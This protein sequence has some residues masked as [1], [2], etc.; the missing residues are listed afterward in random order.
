MSS[1][2]P[3][4]ASLRRRRAALIALLIVLQLVGVASGWAAQPDIGAVAAATRDGRGR[5]ILDLPD[6]GAS[7][8]PPESFSVAV[9]GRPLPA[10]AVPIMSD[11]L[12]MALVVDASQ[13]GRPVL[14]PGLS[15][16]VDFALA[17]SPTTRSTVVAD[18]SPPAVV[19]P[20][21]PGPAA[22]LEG[23]SSI[24]PQGE[25]QTAAAL[26][27]AVQQLPVEADDPRLVVLYTAAEAAD[28]PAADLVA[29][30]TA[31]G[32][33]LAVV[34]VGDE[35]A[36][37]PYWSSVAAAT[38]G[39]AVGARSA[40]VVDAFTRLA[41]ALRTRYLLTFPTPDRL[42]ADAVVRVDAPSGPLTV[43]VAVLAAPTAPAP[44]VGAHAG[45]DPK[46]AVAL[47]LLALALATGVAVLTRARRRRRAGGESPVTAVTTNIPA[48]RDPVVGR[49]PLFREIESALQAGTPAV[50]QA[51]DGSAGVG[52]TTAMIEFAHRNRDR[53][54]VAWW[55]TAEDPPLVAD[56]M[57]QLAEALGLAVPT[58]TV[59]KATT[60]LCDELSRRDRW[61]LI[62]DDG[63]SARELVRFLPAGRG[64]VI[65]GST[66]PGWREHGTTIPMGRFTRAESLELL[67]ARLPGLSTVQADRLAGAVEDLP[68]IVDLAAATIADTGTS[69]D[70]Y[71]ELLADRTEH[72][73][74]D[75]DTDATPG[76]AAWSI[77][78]DRLAVD[79][80][81][82]SV[83]L[84]ATAWLGHE[85]VPIS[86]FTRHPDN[87]PAP[88]AQ[89]ARTP[90][91][92]ADLAATLGRRGLARVTP[93]SVQL[94]RIPGD[95]LLTRT[96]DDRPDHPPW[97]AWAVR[98]LRVAMPVDPHDPR[99]WAEW[100]Q[101][102]PHVLTATDP[103][104]HLDD[105][106][107]EVAWLLNHAAGYL[108]ARG[109]PRAARA[110]F[111]DAYDLTRAQLGDDH[112]DTRASARTLVDDL[113][114]LGQHEQARRV[115]HDAHLGE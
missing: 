2:T 34:A 94:H 68:Q 5:L 21:R 85:P 114:A 9:D 51:V 73:A 18:T 3:T 53:Y 110:L 22:T 60:R 35:G 25:P 52:T 105:V 89:T 113:R 80:P 14:N 57:A 98:L 19:A 64:H 95:L 100:R 70:A 67:Q 17:T 99:G 27:L 28:H 11:R 20:L 106:V 86:L 92:L 87:L 91:G 24:E 79:D 6:A 48:R 65:V 33:V 40:D 71:I 90:S 29:R 109:E 38:G 36:V 56:Q 78:F 47:G 111:E 31:A 112:P 13:A 74:S 44:T 1:S 69:V 39:V 7:S 32:A 102:L 45:V 82:A 81:G 12:A 63:G 43:D 66:D 88:L 37:S 103:A 50:L 54:D 59:G 16:A 75:H 101:L 41:A 55:I 77:A 8:L 93:D 97:A 15:G 23:L 58:D 72:R 61:L 46:L 30:L 76:A 42:P 49:E 115:L 107:V 84:T 62:F 26:D 10:T 96:G 104:R 4:P 83:L 108:K